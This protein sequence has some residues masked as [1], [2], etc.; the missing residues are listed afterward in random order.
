VSAFAAVDNDVRWL[1][2]TG[3][4]SAADENAMTAERCLDL[5]RAG[6][7]DST[8]PLRLLG[9]RFWSSTAVCVDR[10]RHGRVFLVG[11]AAHA[12]TPLGGLGMNCGLAAAHNLAWKLAA[13]IHGTASPSLLDSYEEERKP[14]AIRSCQASLGPA[15]PPARVD[16]LVLG[17]RY[18]S[19]AVISDQ[20][21][22]DPDSD[23]IAT[24]LPSA[25][26]GS[27]APHMWF[28]D[29][30]PRRSTLDL[31]GRSF[32]VLTDATGENQGRGAIDSLNSDGIPAAIEII[33][34]P[35]WKAL[36]GVEP[37][38]GVLVR[39]DGHVGWRSSPPFDAMQVQTAARQI[40]GR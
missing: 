25:A 7:G 1:L 4:F 17:V 36:Y 21:A 10:F 24:Y 35:S 2:I 12:T 22:D 23:D 32:V 38:G 28:T 40:L 29:G 18:A 30:S 20:A 26:A 3:A 6:L 39:P 11:D 33:D 27:R 9:F 14:I 34:H 15:R 13:V 37:G 16:R 31:F 8:V 19:D 5:V